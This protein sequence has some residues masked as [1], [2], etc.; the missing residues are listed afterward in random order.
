[1]SNH[2]QTTVTGD[3]TKKAN[4]MKTD[5]T[6][7]LIRKSKNP[8]KH[9]VAQQVKYVQRALKRFMVRS[10]ETQRKAAADYRWASEALTDFSRLVQRMSE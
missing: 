10:V 2:A 3:V 9:T 7:V 1:M 8:T 5:L 4:E 6:K